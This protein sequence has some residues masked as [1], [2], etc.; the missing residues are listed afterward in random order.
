[1]HSRSQPTAKL[2][3]NNAQKNADTPLSTLYG[4]NSPL[5][6]MHIFILTQLMRRH[7][8]GGLLVQPGGTQASNTRSLLTETLLVTDLRCV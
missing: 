1:M 8:M 4:G 7:G 2:R 3:V 6:R 5:E